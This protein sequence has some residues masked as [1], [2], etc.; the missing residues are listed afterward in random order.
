MHDE[1]TLKEFARWGKTPPEHLPHGTPDII[2]ENMRRLKPNSWKLAG[3]KLIGE[4]E[5]GPLVQFIPT[6]YICVG[7]DED[8]LPKLQKISL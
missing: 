4:T 6:N 5:M 1:R 7:T 2:R 8:G 3:N